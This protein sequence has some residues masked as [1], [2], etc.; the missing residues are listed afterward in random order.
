MTIGGQTLDEDDLFVEVKSERTEDST[1][2]RWV[3]PQGE[4]IVDKVYTIRGGNYLVDLDLRIKNTTGNPISYALETEFSALQNNEQAEGSMFMPPVYLF[5]SICQHGDDFERLPAEDII[6]NIEDEESHENT[7]EDGV[8]WGGIDNRYFMTGLAVKQ[9]IE[10]CTARADQAGENGVPAGYTRV[11]NDLVLASGIIEGKHTESRLLTFYGGPKKLSYLRGEDMP[12]NMS[13]A[14]DFGYFA[15]ICEPM[16]W[17]MRY[18]HSNFPNWGIAII[19]LTILVKLLTLPLTIKQYRSMAAMKK[20]GPQLK[21]IQEKHKEDKVRLQQEMMK[22][23]R[24]NQVNPLSGCLPMIMMMPVY[25]ALYRTIYS[26]VEL[27][28]ADFALWI[29]DLSEQDPYYISP[30][31]LGLL[32]IIQMRLNPSAGDQAQQKI[33]MWVMPIMFTG[34]MLFLPSGL[35]LYILVNTLLGIV[36]QWYMYQVPVHS[37]RV[38]RFNIR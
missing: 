28:Q 26:A 35:V 2:L 9:G 19:L 31:I 11:Y 7:F 30:F 32:M 6:E 21:K 12:V 33:L 34:M 27:Y 1:T 5:N 20:L 23:Y 38:H 37:I 15:F 16:L 14:I 10:S 18:S 4:F 8:A 22:L 36:Q 17:L 3:D 29:T 24:E 13:E 25:F